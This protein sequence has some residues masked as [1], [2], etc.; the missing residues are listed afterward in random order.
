MSNRDKNPIDDIQK[1]REELKQKD[2]II[3]RL[4]RMLSATKSRAAG[5]ARQ[6]HSSPVKQ[7]INDDKVIPIEEARRK[8]R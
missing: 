2:Q 6:A 8:M 5:L 7:A 3:D 4:T 1:L